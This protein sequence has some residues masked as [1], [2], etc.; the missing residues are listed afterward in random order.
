VVEICH[1][2]TGD[3]RGNLD[4]HVEAGHAPGKLATQCECDA[5]RGIEVGAGNAAEHQDDYREDCTGRKRVAKQ[6]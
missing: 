2:G 5:D 6:C 4:G 1:T 3:G